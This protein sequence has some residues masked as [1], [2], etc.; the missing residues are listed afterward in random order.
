[1][2]DTIRRI[3]KANYDIDNISRIETIFNDVV[4][5]FSGD[6][7]GYQ[8]CDTDYHDL[9]HTFQV[10]KP[11]FQIIDGWNRSGQK[12]K[13][14]YKF[15]ELGVIAVLLHDSGYIKKSGDDDGTG[16]KYT[17][18]HIGRSIQFARE[19]L[20]SK[21]F[22]LGFNDILAV[23]N[24]IRCTGVLERDRRFTCNEERI[25]GYALGIADLI[26]QLSAKNYPE[27]LPVLYNEFK[28]AYDYEGLDRLRKRNISIFESAD[29]L[30][31]STPV[32]YKSVVLRRFKD[33]GS[34][35]R[36]LD[37]HQPY[38]AKYYDT[39]IAENIS[40]IGSATFF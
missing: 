22:N 39:A 30:I 1:M 24:M 13:V 38:T 27:K 21:A 29:A 35:D 3:V 18:V 36:Y 8:G 16:A 14:S 17:F 12:P 28:E 25:C 20:S 32:F 9:E 11:F 33:M 10:L 2:I 34:L 37:Y 23:G 26:G 31:D 15:F 6:F 40:K 19:Y 7:Q 4:R 5:L